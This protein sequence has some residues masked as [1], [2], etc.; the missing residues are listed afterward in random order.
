MQGHCYIEGLT[1]HAQEVLIW[2]SQ[3]S[4]GSSK[5]GIHR[6]DTISKHARV[7]TSIQGHLAHLER[8]IA[9]L[10]WRQQSVADG[11][12]LGDVKAKVDE[13]HETAQSEAHYLGT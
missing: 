10:D 12:L 11:S 2:A 13:C 6:G 1:S 5:R 4:R 7:L 3:G 9:E 8:Q